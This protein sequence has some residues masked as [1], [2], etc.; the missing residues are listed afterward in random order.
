MWALSEYSKMSYHI[1]SHTF[2][3]T[4]T[5]GA[6]C[7]HSSHISRTVYKVSVIKFIC[8]SIHIFLGGKGDMQISL[9]GAT[10][11][12]RKEWYS[13]CRIGGGTIPNESYMRALHWGKT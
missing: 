1:Q 11:S 9:Q 8:G 10:K 6:L 2:T 7:P 13:W 12:Y 3:H 4:N 5:A